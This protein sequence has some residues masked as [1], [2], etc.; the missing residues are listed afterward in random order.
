MTLIK[1]TTNYL[2]E[3]AGLYA[4]AQPLRPRHLPVFIAEQYDFYTLK[5]GT[6]EVLG[7]A[8]RETTDPLV[9]RVLAE[10][11]EAFSPAALAKHQVHFPVKENGFVLIAH[12]L[13]NYTR[14]RLIEMKVPFIVPH[15]QLYWPTLGLEVRKRNQESV[16]IKGADTMAPAEQAVVMGI[17]N[18]LLPATFQPKDL[19]KMLGY[20]LMS[21]TRAV[22][23]LE[24][25]GLGKSVKKGINRLFTP[26][27]KHDLWKQAFPYLKNPVRGTVRLEEHDMHDEAKI[28]AGESALVR[29]SMLG[30]PRTPTYAVARDQWKRLQSKAISRLTT[31]E[32]GTCAVQVWRY[33][34]ALFAKDSAVDVFSLYLSLR[35]SHDERI[36]MALEEAIKEYL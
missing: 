23:I 27:E 28:L 8:L 1:D 2:T 34:P 25:A 11:K 21:M 32:P 26:I 33:D 35:D 15:V 6:L 16:S 22:K 10:E 12:R 31:E 14:K 7:V 13:E 5:L 20:N 3:V 36:A 9:V 30:A 24:A 29:I 17:M 4:A 18:G 19:E